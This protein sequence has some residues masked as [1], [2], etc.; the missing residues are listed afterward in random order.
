[1]SDSESR[2]TPTFTAQYRETLGMIVRMEWG[3]EFHRAA[4]RAAL[5]TI[6]RLAAAVR[7]WQDTAWAEQRRA[8]AAEEGRDALM[9]V[10]HEYLADA[11]RWG[12]DGPGVR[13]AREVIAQVKATAAA[14]GS[15]QATD[16]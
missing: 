6:D 11:E 15:G 16:G 14:A 5:A 10:A 2:D 9:A 13:K 7:E 3:P 8:E 4:I 1:M 12:I